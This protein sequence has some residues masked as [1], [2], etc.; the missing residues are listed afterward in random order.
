M[1]AKLPA[2]IDIHMSSQGYSWWQNFRLLYMVKKQFS[3][4]HS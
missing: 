1:V 2:F 3:Q 4:G